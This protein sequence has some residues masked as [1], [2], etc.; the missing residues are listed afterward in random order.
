[1][2]IRFVNKPLMSNEAEK[3]IKLTISSVAVTEIPYKDK[4]DGS[5]QVLRLQAAYAHTVDR[6]GVPGL[7]PEKFEF[8]V[9][10]EGVY[11]PGDYTL[12]PSAF[13]VRNG[14][15]NFSEARLVPLKPAAKAQAV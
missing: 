4:K 15:L 11:Q 5:S 2:M 14:R 3:M 12:H 10:R 7:Y 13:Y 1:M 6:E 8:P 9:P